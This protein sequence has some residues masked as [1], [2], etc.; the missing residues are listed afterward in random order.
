[1]RILR[2]KGRLSDVA[3]CMT[4]DPQIS[5]IDADYRGSVPD[6]PRVLSSESAEI[7]EICGSILWD[8][9]A[10]RTEQVT[11]YTARTH[12]GVD[13]SGETSR[14]FARKPNEV[15]IF[16]PWSPGLRAYTKD[17][18]ETPVPG[19]RLVRSP[20]CCAG[21]VADPLVGFT[22]PAGWPPSGFCWS[23]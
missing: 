16:P 9:G 22:S 11:F 5:Q 1:M 3:L 12:P 7:C 18:P 19:P 2:R 23:G 8:C 21:C 20:L 6:C 10:L 14:H 4:N 17:L 15:L 13:F